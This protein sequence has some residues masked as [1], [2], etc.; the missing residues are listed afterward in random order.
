MLD[1]QKELE[2][3]LKSA[4]QSEAGNIAQ[5]LLKSKKMYGDVPVIVESV[6]GGDPEQ[7]RLLV[8]GLRDHFQGLAVLA[9][10][11]DEKV[12]LLV[13]V[14]PDWVKKGLH[15]GKLIKELASQVGGGGGGRPDLAQAG[16]KDP[17]RLPDALR[18][19]ESLLGRQMSAIS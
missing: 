10:T 4:Q 5:D 9:G 14:S 15:A 3:K 2:K 19:V 6:E 1:H 13:Y 18:S 11:T 8:D 12:S 16:G 17:S 7:L